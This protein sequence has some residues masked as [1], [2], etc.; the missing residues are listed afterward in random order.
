MVAAA[1]V[2][3][4]APGCAPKAPD[5]QSIWS[6]SSSAPA[7]TTTSPSGE[8]PIPIATYLER[9]GVVGEPIPADKLTD[10]TVTFPTP[11]G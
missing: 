7:A 1:L 2:V 4:S 5:Y 9:K 11:P 6:T 10:L 3:F 8:E